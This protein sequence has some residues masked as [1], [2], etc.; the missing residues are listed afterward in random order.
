M[1]QIQYS[2]FLGLITSIQS[3]ESE[4]FMTYISANPV[5]QVTT[6]MEG[7]AGEINAKT[8]LSRLEFD[9]PTDI[10]DEGAYAT[11]GILLIIALI[12]ASV[13]VL[14]AWRAKCRFRRNIF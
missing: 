7:A 9:W 8:K 6:V 1:K 4:V 11:I 5:L 14:F 10:P 3:D 13:G 12:Y 2:L